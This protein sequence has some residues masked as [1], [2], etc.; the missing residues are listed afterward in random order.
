MKLKAMLAMPLLLATMTVPVFADH[1]KVDYNHSTQFSALRTYSWSAVHTTNSIWDARVKDAIDKQL[2]AKGYTEV[3]TGGAVSLVAVEKI[4]VHQQ[5]DTTYEG[6]GGRR[7][8]GGVGDA[9][10]SVDDYKVGT[11]IVSMF[12]GNSRQPIWRGTASRDLAGNPEKNTKKLDSDIQK[13]FTGFP[14]RPAA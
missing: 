5:V 11:L 10:T 7:F 4:S 9:T 12:D 13:M 3:P 14:P 6:F 1:V 8:M 2:T